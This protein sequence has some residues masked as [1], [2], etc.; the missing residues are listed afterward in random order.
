MTD[1]KIIYMNIKYALQSN[2][3]RNVFLKNIEMLY[4]ITFNASLYRYIII[5]L[6]LFITQNIP[7]ESFSHF[8]NQVAFRPRK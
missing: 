1:N 4:S 2:R 3:I 6:P 5:I 7:F 8:I